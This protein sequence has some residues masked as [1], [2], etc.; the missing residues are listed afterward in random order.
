MYSS[1]S[2]RNKNPPGATI[3]AISM[4]SRTHDE[5]DVV[6]E[7]ALVEL[8]EAKKSS[9]NSCAATAECDQVRFNVA[10]LVSL[11]VSLPLF[12]GAG[13]DGKWGRL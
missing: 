5:F 13:E 11:R 10:E 2:S 9:W 7:N 8:F 6:G 4:A 12:S 1:R 3:R